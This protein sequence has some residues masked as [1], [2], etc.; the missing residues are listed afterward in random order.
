MAETDYKRNPTNFFQQKK[1]SVAAC[2]ST[3]SAQTLV[4]AGFI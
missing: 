3:I 2:P 4:G 1:L